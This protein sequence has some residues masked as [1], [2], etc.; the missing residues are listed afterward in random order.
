VDLSQKPE[1]YNLIRTDVERVNESL[2]PPAKVRK[3]V[4]LHKEFDPDEA[5]LTRTRKL[6]RTFMEG[7]YQ[8]MIDAMYNGLDHVVVRA[9]VKYRDGRMGV[10]ETPVRVCV[11]DSQTSFTVDGTRHS[12]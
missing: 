5:E 1:V 12:K 10:V 2:P 9:E 11:L 6:R 7:R 8:Q 3:F 4:L